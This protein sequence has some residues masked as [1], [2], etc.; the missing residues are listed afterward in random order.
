[1]SRNGTRGKVLTVE[2]K[3]RLEGQ[4]QLDEKLVIVDIYSAA[5]F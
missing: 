3:I 5:V 4:Q 1:M 2:V